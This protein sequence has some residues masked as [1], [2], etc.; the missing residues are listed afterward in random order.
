MRSLFSLVLFFFSF[1]VSAANGELKTRFSDTNSEFSLRSPTFARI[2][3]LNARLTNSTV[4]N[5]DYAIR[6]LRQA[7]VNV[8]LDIN[9]GHNQIQI[10]HGQVVSD[11]PFAYKSYQFT[12]SRFFYSQTSAIGIALSESSRIQPQQAFIDPVTAATRNRP[13][14]LSAKR[15]ELFYEQILSENIRG[16]YSLLLGQ[17]SADRPDHSGIEIRHSY[18]LNNTTAFRLDLGAIAENKNQSLK[19]EKGYFSAYWSELTASFQ[20]NLFWML[21]FGAG[22]ILEHEYQPS[23]L[24][25]N[26]LTQ[27][28]ADTYFFKAIYQDVGWQLSVSSKV[29]SSNLGS[30]SE[31]IIGEFSWEI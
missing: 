10:A 29:T 2:F 25:L 17:R 14:S 31:S 24:I 28:G 6:N 7:N 11:S 5:P 30:Y 27:T 3:T 1:Q 8:G 18:A 22:T 13:I 19:D 26:T 9:S 12:Y 20:P 4:D 15:Q 21:Q 16:R 23:P